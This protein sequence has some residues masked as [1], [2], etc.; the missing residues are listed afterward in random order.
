MT[1]TKRMAKKKLGLT[2]DYALARLMMCTRAAVSH[3]PEDEAIP[4]HRQTYLRA[5]YPE[6]FPEKRK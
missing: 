5:L 1:I 6:K 4:K 3:W 2:S